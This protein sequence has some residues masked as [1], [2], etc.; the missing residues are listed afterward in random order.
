VPPAELIHAI[1]VGFRFPQQV[2]DLFRALLLHESSPLSSEAG[3][4]FFYSALIFE[5]VKTTGLGIVIEELAL[6]FIQA[7]SEA[8]TCNHESSALLSKVS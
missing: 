4:R 8:T 7:S 1:C 6:Q 5:A 3:R 2:D